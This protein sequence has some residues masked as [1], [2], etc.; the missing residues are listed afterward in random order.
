MEKLTFPE[1]L[2][3]LAVGWGQSSESCQSVRRGHALH[4]RRADPARRR[5]SRT[6]PALR[7]A[8]NRTSLE[9]EMKKKLECWRRGG[10][11]AVRMPDGVRR[12]GEEAAGLR[13]RR[14]GSPAEKRRGLWVGSEEACRPH[15]PVKWS[16]SGL[17]GLR[18]GRRRCVWRDAEGGRGCEGA[19]QA[20]PQ[21]RRQRRRRKKREKEGEGRSVGVGPKGPG[22]WGGGRMGGS[23]LLPLEPGASPSPV[24]AEKQQVCA[25]LGDNQNQS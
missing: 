5:R 13:V 4:E 22:A 25:G 19:A 3:S 7:G 20:C 9:V 17:L 2:V 12:R 21:S 16:W 1:K 6:S 11:P 14:S 10:G 23:A 15:C 24:S 8:R 18:P